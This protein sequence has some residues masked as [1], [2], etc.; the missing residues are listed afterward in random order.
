MGTART[1]TNIRRIPGRL[2]VIFLCTVCLP[3]YAGA[4]APC[5]TDQRCHHQ[6]RHHAR[7]AAPNLARSSNLS[8]FPAGFRGKLGTISNRRGSL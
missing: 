1:I 4:A 3:L 7:L 6:S 5:G 8:T 2:G